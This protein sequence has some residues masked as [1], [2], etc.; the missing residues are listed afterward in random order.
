MRK[1]QF[2]R[3]PVGHIVV[4][5]QIQQ[6]FS[7]SALT[8]S[9]TI[10]PVDG[11]ANLGPL[12][13]QIEFQNLFWNKTLVSLEGMG[14]PSPETIW[15][16]PYPLDYTTTQKIPKLPPPPAYQS[17]PSPQL[18]K[19]NLGIEGEPNGN[20]SSIGHESRSS[21][22]HT[23]LHLP[24]SWITVPRSRGDISPASLLTKVPAP[25]RVYPA[26]IE[27]QDAFWGQVQ[28]PTANLNEEFIGHHPI[29]AAEGHCYPVCDPS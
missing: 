6:D 11:N 16:R 14:Q 21:V 15:I 3:H 12:P 17:K 9:A 4:P 25:I 5:G 19:E 20:G 7:I 23:T 28:V 10:E 29:P 13:L 27:F 2:P 22:P 24:S 18:L 8:N 26:H 1:L